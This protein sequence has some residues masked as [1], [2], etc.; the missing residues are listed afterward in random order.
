MNSVIPR[1]LEV[2]RCLG[3]GLLHDLVAL[4]WVG[5]QMKDL[6]FLDESMHMLSC[7]INTLSS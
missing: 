6:I 2:G 5:L 7:T 1:W 3:F 4:G